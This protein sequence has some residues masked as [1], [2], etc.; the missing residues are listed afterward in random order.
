M[1]L[2]A[3]C[4]ALIQSLLRLIHLVLNLVMQEL[5]N[6]FNIPFPFMDKLILSI[7]SHSSFQ[8][9]SIKSTSFI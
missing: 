3:C 8:E 1:F 6:I 5:T 2:A 9:G 4:D 7:Y